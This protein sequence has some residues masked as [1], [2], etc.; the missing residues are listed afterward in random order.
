MI[1]APQLLA[2]GLVERDHVRRLI[3]M[4]PDDDERVA[5]E[6]R[7]RSFAELVAHLLVAEVGLPDQLAVHVVGVEAARFEVGEKVRA[8]GDRRARGPRAVV[9]VRRFVRLFLARHLLQMVL[10]VLR[11][12]ASTLY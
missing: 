12:I 2:R 3:E 4:I 8:V 10:P 11:S 7:R 6:D 5:V 1:D 9:L